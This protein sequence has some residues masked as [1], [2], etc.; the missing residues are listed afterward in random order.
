[1]RQIDLDLADV[2]FIDSSGL[3]LILRWAA[4]SRR[5]GFAFAVAGC[6]P[7]ARRLFA[8]TRTS[9]LLDRAQT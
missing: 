5:D 9:H 1:M 4:E 7:Q 6:S 3:H 2:T 8:M